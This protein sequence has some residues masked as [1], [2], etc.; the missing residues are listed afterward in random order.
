MFFL[1]YLVWSFRLVFL[2]F[3]A[4]FPFSVCAAL[5]RWVACETFIFWP[6]L[7]FSK[8]CHFCRLEKFWMESKQPKGFHEKQTC[9]SL[10]PA[11][12]LNHKP[13]LSL[14]IFSRIFH[15]KNSHF[16]ATL[17]VVCIPP[18]NDSFCSLYRASWY[19][20]WWAKCDTLLSQ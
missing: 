7:P 11:G 19:F 9:Y 6:F 18:A 1:K 16:Q 20:S 3:S 15:P 5:F 14:H 17:A 4:K 13:H 2:G 10:F 12:C 8:F